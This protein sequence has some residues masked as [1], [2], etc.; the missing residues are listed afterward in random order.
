M[1]RRHQPRPRRIPRHP[2]QRLQPRRPIPD[3]IPRPEPVRLH[4]VDLDPHRLPKDQRPGDLP[5]LPPGTP[6]TRRH[7]HTTPRP[8]DM[9]MQ[10]QRWLMIRLRPHPPT[11]MRTRQ[12]PISSSPPS[13]VPLRVI[14]RRFATINPSAGA[15]SPNHTES[16]RTPLIW[17]GDA[18]T[19]GK[20]W[21]GVSKKPGVLGCGGAGWSCMQGGWV[22]VG[23]VVVAWLHGGVGDGVTVGLAVDSVGRL[24]SRCRRSRGR[25]VGGSAGFMASL[26]TVAE[27]KSEL[28]TCWTRRRWRWL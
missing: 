4:H 24:A 10:A 19:G 14:R 9:L 2:P 25:W 11:P 26:V 6:P 17:G 15:S 21:C 20:S 16:Q 3:R 5:G 7:Q 27:E 22:V 8:L 23:P 18:K 13:L 28:T 1:R 12:S